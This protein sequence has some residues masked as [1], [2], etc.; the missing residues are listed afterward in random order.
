MPNEKIV[1]K[2]GEVTIINKENPN[3]YVLKENYV[4]EA[5]NT[6]NTF[7]TKDGEYFVMGDNRN[8]SSDSRY[9]GVLP[10]KLMVGRALLR[11][12]P[13]GEISYLPGAVI[14]NK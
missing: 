8:Q 12:L 11:L 9:W 10:R 3:G 14:E 2:N 6:T 7:E 1:I 4:R 5:F 13:V